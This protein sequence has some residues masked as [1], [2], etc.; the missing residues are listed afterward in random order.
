M[1]AKIILM[2]FTE[3][4]FMKKFIIV[5]ALISIVQSIVKGQ[6]AQ[7]YRANIVQPDT[8]KEVKLFD[9]DQY[10]REVEGFKNVGNS[11]ENIINVFQ[12]KIEIET[13]ETPVVDVDKLTKE[14]KELKAEIARINKKN[15][16]LEQQEK[17][18]LEKKELE[19]KVLEEKIMKEEER[20]KMS[21][22]TDSI[23]LIYLVRD[24]NLQ[25][26]NSKAAFKQTRE[27]IYVI[28]KTLG[29][30]LDN[31]KEKRD[32]IMK[33][34][35]QL[36]SLKD[37]S[38]EYKND[39]DILSDTISKAKNYYGKLEVFIKYLDVQS[40]KSKIL[41]DTLSVRTARLMKQ[42]EDSET[43]WK[44]EKLSSQA[45]NQDI[46]GA[47]P[48]IAIKNKVAPSITLLGAKEF[49]KLGLHKISIYAGNDN[50]FDT[51]MLAQLVTPE[52]SKYG[53][54]FSGTYNLKAITNDSSYKSVFNYLININSK[55]FSMLSN[56]NLEFTQLNIKLGYENI[57]VDKVLSLYGSLNYNTP[58]S[59]KK[60][61]LSA[62]KFSN[63]TQYYFDFGVKVLLGNEKVNDFGFYLD[64]NFFNLT[65][66]FKKLANTE[67]SLGLSSIKVGVQKTF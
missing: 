32:E 60:E 55:D 2:I 45:N 15:N 18:V 11:F 12:Q 58:L 17:R 5:I 53:I 52:V 7:L 61:F 43:T 36:F 20:K 10:L 67:D 4:L 62:T 33:M 35:K 54:N 27:H 19:R 59:R 3:N 14:M 39:I 64:L 49:K 66:D 31:D 30:L 26:E 9:K 29:H 22:I 24:A 50:D 13:Q 38:D 65:D 46:I 51:T 63:A 1:W 8:I 40:K 48:Q 28:E 57:I 23:N 47:L 56:G 21:H 42:I 25:I 37:D 41:Y 16:K 44:K 6:V 34:H